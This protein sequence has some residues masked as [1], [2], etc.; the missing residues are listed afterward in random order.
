M[1]TES[2][3]IFNLKGES[4]SSIGNNIK[5]LRE[6]HKFTPAAVAKKLD[7]NVQDYNAWESGLLLPTIDKV[8][9]ICAIYKINSPTELFSD[10]FIQ[11]YNAK[12]VR[13]L[14]ELAMKK[15]QDEA[16]FNKD[17]DAKLN[18]IIPKD[19]YHS[20]P[21][22]FSISIVF[23][24]VLLLGFLL[25]CFID[26]DIR[27]VGYVAFNLD[28]V[29]AVLVYVSAILCLVFVILALRYN[30]LIV[31]Y[32]EWFPKKLA[33]NI[34]L[35]Y[36]LAPIFIMIINSIVFILNS[37]RYDFGLPIQTAVSI[38]MF[39]SSMVAI[40]TIKPAKPDSITYSYVMKFSKYKLRSD[41]PRKALSVFSILGIVVS[42]ISV[43]FFVMQL[44]VKDGVVGGLFKVT[45]GAI[46][47]FSNAFI[48]LF[49]YV[50]SSIVVTIILSICAVIFIY[51]QISDL[52]LSMKLKR[53]YHQGIIKA[54]DVKTTKRFDI[55]NLILGILVYVI[56][57]TTIIL[58][59]TSSADARLAS[60]QYFVIPVLSAISV[61]V[62]V[63]LALN[64]KVFFCYRGAETVEVTGFSEVELDERAKLNRKTRVKNQDKQKTEKIKKQ[65]SKVDNVN[66]NVQSS[67]QT[68]SQDLD[69]KQLTNSNL[70]NSN[71]SNENA[72]SKTQPTQANA[73]VTIDEVKNTPDTNK[74]GQNNG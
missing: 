57:F 48:T 74:G 13:S 27:V 40:S 9:S 44:V 31:S 34:R 8:M 30:F 4:M 52:I 41:A 73:K 54:D 39:L 11:T 65:A 66:Q 6:H 24:F 38:C 19:S 60:S 21:L 72:V 5:F 46:Y 51:L 22:F 10:S 15:A 25:P 16:A 2:V 29:T 43:V 42:V 56:V 49:D 61:L 7:I 64:I 58:G 1:I 50:N 33:T 28:V 32:N 26:G 20:S 69:N 67:E 23:G 71:E 47:N 35:L 45:N 3:F 55:I 12:E 59:L 68:L 37:K 53:Q 17:T 36:V 70:E 14:R 62:C 18:F 63:R